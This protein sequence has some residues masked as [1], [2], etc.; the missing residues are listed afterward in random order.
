MPVKWGK[1]AGYFGKL[2]VVYLIQN[3]SNFIIFL[4]G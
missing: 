2:E 3:I 1:S 4:I